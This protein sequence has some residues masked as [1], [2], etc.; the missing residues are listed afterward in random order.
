GARPGG[1]RSPPPSPGSGGGA[2][3][4]PPSP[5][6]VSDPIYKDCIGSTGDPFA[7]SRLCR[8]LLPFAIGYG[9]GIKG[10]L[11]RLGFKRGTKPGYRMEGLCRLVCPHTRD[12][13]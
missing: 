10:W 2:G 7:R 6:S 11:E 9:Q 8:F 4:P 5:A 3:T 12:L 1:R 13:Q